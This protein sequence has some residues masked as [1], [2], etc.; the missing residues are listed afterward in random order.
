MRLL[1]KDVLLPSVISVLKIL[2][3]LLSSKIL[4]F[5]PVTWKHAIID[6]HQNFDSFSLSLILY[7]LLFSSKFIFDVFVFHDLL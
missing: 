6:M 3:L 5:S 4:K 7:S 1:V 2:H